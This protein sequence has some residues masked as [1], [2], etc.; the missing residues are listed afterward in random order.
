MMCRLS[1]QIWFSNGNTISV[2]ISALA[3]KKTK[4]KSKQ[5]LCLSKHPRW[6]FGYRC[7]KS[8]QRLSIENISQQNCFTRTD[9]QTTDYIMLEFHLGINF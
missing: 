9:E 2:Q 5:V 6:L 8:K 7:L 3:A 4:G 1:I